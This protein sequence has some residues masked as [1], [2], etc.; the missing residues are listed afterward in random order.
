MTLLSSGPEQEAVLLWRKGPRTLKP[1]LTEHVVQLSDPHPAAPCRAGPC[2]PPCATARCWAR[3]VLP[4]GRP[5]YEQPLHLLP[6]GWTHSP[7]AR[8]HQQLSGQARCQG[9]PG[10]H[11]CWVTAVGMGASSQQ[12]SRV[13]SL[14]PAKDTPRRQVCPGFNY[15]SVLQT[16]APHPR[17]GKLFTH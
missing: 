1:G 17:S 11:T 4:G 3:Q 16:L 8:S 7:R 15:V 12:G 13:P 5:C 10:H 9:H 6:P 2:S 14:L